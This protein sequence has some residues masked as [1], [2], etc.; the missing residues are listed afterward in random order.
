MPL[1]AD[2]AMGTELLARSGF[3]GPPCRLNL[4]RPELV[5]NLH[6]EYVA[7]GAGLLVANTLGGSP[8]ETRAGVRLAR[9][10]A[11]KSPRVCP[12]GHPLA[13]LAR[14]HSG[15]LVAASVTPMPSDELIEAAADADFIILETLTSLEPLKAMRESAGLPLMVTLS[16]AQNGVLASFT[17]AEVAARLE[18]LGLVAFGYGCGFGPHAARQVMAELREAAPGAVLIA[19]PNLGLPPYAVTPAHLAA[20]A[21]DMVEMDVDIVGACCGSTPAHIDAVARIMSG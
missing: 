12:P 4:L 14:V 13:G 15:A 19:K 11:E 20:W 10:A 8:S 21:A 3:A 7:A 6:L 17:P 2:G 16:F 1:V 18:P 5:L 9:E